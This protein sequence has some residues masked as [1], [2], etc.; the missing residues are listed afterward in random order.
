MHG[1]KYLIVGRIEGKVHDSVLWQ[2]LGWTAT[3]YKQ[4]HNNVTSVSCDIFYCRIAYKITVH[5]MQ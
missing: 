2:S 5:G 1:R 3:I 4:I